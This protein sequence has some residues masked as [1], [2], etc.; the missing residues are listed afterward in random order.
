MAKLFRGLG[1]LLAALVVI[2][3]VARI[4]FV[5]VW[6]IPED[7]ARLSVSAEPT[8]SGGDTVLMLTRGEPG[9]GDLVRCTDPDDPTHFVVGRIGGIGGDTV[10]VNG[11]ELIVDGKRYSG[12]MA[13]AI[14]QLTIVHPTSGEKLVLGCDQVPMGGKT[15]MRGYSGKKDITTP[16]KATVEMGKVFLVSDDR[17]YPDDS[18]TFGTV[19]VSSCKGQIF[20]RLWS[21]SGYHDEKR[22]FTY[23]R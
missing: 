14:E 13:C 20:F 5:D 6:K 9:F 1:W 3:V 16:V 8:L 11:R 12:E 18:R 23:V 19:P 7:D 15:H 10:Q 22:R 2:G 17:S 21:T 4:F